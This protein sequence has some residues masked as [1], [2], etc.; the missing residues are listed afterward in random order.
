MHA[1]SRH[2]VPHTVPKVSAVVMM[3]GLRRGW[4]TDAPACLSPVCQGISQVGLFPA[5]LPDILPAGCGLLLLLLQDTP[6]PLPGAP[7]W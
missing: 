5:S 6:Q 4:S 3:T 1:W 2:P 7:C